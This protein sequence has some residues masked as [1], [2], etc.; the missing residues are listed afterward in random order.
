M[1]ST[2]L[3]KLM[4]IKKRNLSWKLKLK[5]LVLDLI[6]WGIW[7]FMLQ[8]IWTNYDIINTVPIL[9]G[10]YLGDIFLHMLALVGIAIVFA[11]LWSFLSQGHR[12]Y[13]DNTE[14]K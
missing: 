9:D 4:I 6:T 14:T 2:Q 10:I 3:Q 11:I 12:K 13:I 1:A 7:V 8:F 5:S